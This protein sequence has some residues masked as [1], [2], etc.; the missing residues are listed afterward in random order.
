LC[1][2]PPPN[3]RQKPPKNV[4]EKNKI[5]NEVIK[6]LAEDFNR[7]HEWKLKEDEKKKSE[8]REEKAS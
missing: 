8:A 2:Y 4:S 7:F 5:K 1:V 6:N 3:A